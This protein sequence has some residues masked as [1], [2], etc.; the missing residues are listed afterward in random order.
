M[1]ASL[2]LDD[3]TERELEEL[4]ESEE[5]SKSE[6]VR[7]AVKEFYLKEKRASENI[8]YFIDLYRK[9]VVTKDLLLVLLPIKD[10]ENI[11]IGEKVGKDAARKA[12]SLSGNY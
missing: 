1:R 4:K 12:K 7:E 8:K 2:V 9:G 3:E 6:I 10:A 5:K 11:I